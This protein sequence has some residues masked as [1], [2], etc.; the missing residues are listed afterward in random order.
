M[1]TNPVEFGFVAALKREVSGLISSSGPFGKINLEIPG[2]AQRIYYTQ[3]AALICAGTGVTRAYAASKVLVEKFA[4]RMLISMGFAGACVPDMRPGAIVVPASVQDAGT[5]K[6][7]RCAFGSGQ[8]VTLDR[9]AG[10]ALKQDAS[11]RFGALAVDMEA[12]GVAT[13]AAEAGIEFAAIKV[14]SDGANQDME[15]LADFV[16]P[17]GF[18]TGRF[19]AHIALRP[20]LWPSVAALQVNSK[21]ASAALNKAV[22]ECLGDCRGFAAK[23]S[24]IARVYERGLQ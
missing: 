13:A 10:T 15:F 4:P 12:V 3:G 21:L 24:G 11:D 18:K 6:T 14:I 1:S 8:L 5:G 23:H 9:V 16:K 22:N 7:F 2:L 17:E 20:E 19:L